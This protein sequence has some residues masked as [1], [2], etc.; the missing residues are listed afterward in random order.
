MKTKGNA[1]LAQALRAQGVDTLFF[2]MG[3]PIAIATPK[4]APIRGLTGQ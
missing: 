2:I 4:S 3:M 1:P